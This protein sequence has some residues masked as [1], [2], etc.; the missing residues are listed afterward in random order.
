MEFNGEKLI[1]DNFRDVLMEYSVDIQ[2]VV[3]SAILDDIDITEFIDACADMPYK[4]DQIRLS[5][6]E[7]TKDMCNLPNGEMIYQVRK[8]KRRG[9]DIRQLENQLSNGSLNEEYINF[10]ISLIGEGISISSLDIAII[11]KTLLETFEYGLRSGI[12]MKPFNNGKAYKPKYIRYCLQIIQNNKPVSV[13]LD[14]EWSLEVLEVLS[15]FSKVN[16]YRWNN[17][18]NHIDSEISKVRLDKVVE[19]VKNNIN[20]DTLQTKESGK[21]VYADECLDLVLSAHVS[22]LDYEN[23]ILETRDPVEI[24]Q[25]LNEME[26]NRRKK[27]G[28][29]V[30]K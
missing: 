30:T 26:L 25:K 10:A 13:F 1:L 12:D 5:L 28:G 27:V 2:D 7:K 4:L 19:L 14:G 16:D 11:P 24:K 18:M 8:L 6:K 20:L 9:V 17:L 15:V 21:Y 23:V 3:R 29:R 22:K